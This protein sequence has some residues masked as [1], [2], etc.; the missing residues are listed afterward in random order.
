MSKKQSLMKE[1]LSLAPP[2]PDDK[3]FSAIKKKG[4]CAVSLYENFYLIALNAFSN[5]QWYSATN[6][7]PPNK[8][9]GFSSIVL[10]RISF[11]KF[12][13]KFCH[14]KI[15]KTGHRLDRGREWTSCNLEM[16]LSK[17]QK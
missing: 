3:F 13:C 5:H 4:F 9:R 15:T 2:Q 8:T 16:R 10:W 14:W 17:P 7:G 12:I 1:R 11:I 6:W